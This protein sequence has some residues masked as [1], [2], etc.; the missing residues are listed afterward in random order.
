MDGKYQKTADG[1][2]LGHRPLP[3]ARWAFDASVTD[4]FADMIRRSIP[5]YD[6][7]RALV[8]QLACRFIKPK[9]D[10][11]DLGASRGAQIE[12]LFDKLGATVRWVLV[13]KSPDM[14]AVL[15]ERFD[16]AQECGYVEVKDLDLRKGYPGVAASLTLAVLTLQFIPVEHRAR[17][18]QDAYD[19]TLPGGALIVVEKVVGSTS[20]LA[21][22][23]VDEYHALK[24][25]NGYSQDEIDAKADSLEGAMVPLSAEEN[26]RMLRAAGFRHVETFWRDLNFCG[27]LC[28]KA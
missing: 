24:R 10:V 6:R 11:V 23:F 4:V 22:T 27:W 8:H 1:T 25:A 18:V 2:S 15:R 12:P 13:E 7:M 14:L 28:V 19:R 16:C 3:G 9:T 17:V 21:K 26:E 20:A 5:S